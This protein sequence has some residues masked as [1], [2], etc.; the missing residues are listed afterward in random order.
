VVSAEGEGVAIGHGSTDPENAR[1]L[2]GLIRW[3][4]FAY[5]FDGDLTGA[6]DDDVPDMEA[7]I[8]ARADHLREAPLPGGALDVAKLS[9][10]GLRSATQQAWVDWLLPADGHDRN[11]VVGSN[12]FYLRSPAQSVLDRVGARVTGGFVWVTRLGILPG[13]HDRMRVADGAVVVEVRDRGA[14]YRVFVWKD[15]VEQQES[16]YEASRP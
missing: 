12:R 9:H 13:S 1:S 4:E 6:G 14:R 5:A 8:A 11:A 7:F 10:H 3:G 15:G 2:G 16:D